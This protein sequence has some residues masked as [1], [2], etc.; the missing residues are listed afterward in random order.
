M[1]KVNYSAISVI[2]FASAFSGTLAAL[3]LHQ[4]LETRNQKIAL[5]ADAY[6]RYDDAGSEENR[7]A[8]LNRVITE[9]TQAETQPQE[10]S[11]ASDEATILVTYRKM[12]QNMN[13]G[14]ASALCRTWADHIAFG[15]SQ[16]DI[17]PS[18]TDPTPAL[19]E[20]LLQISPPL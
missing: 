10:A 13:Y 4:Y 11:K 12:I 1:S 2:V 7:V 8:F 16:L 18:A 14:R 20:K 3:S 5:A 9:Q 19:C 17:E 15:K 6:Y